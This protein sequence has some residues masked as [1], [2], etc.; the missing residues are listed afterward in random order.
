MTCAIGEE[1]GSSVRGP[2]EANNVVDLSPTQELVSRHGM[3]GMGINTRV[4]PICRNIEDTARILDAIAGY[5]PKDPLTVFSIGRSPKSHYRTFA[6][7]RDL[8]GLRIGVVRE[9]ST[10]T[11]FRSTPPANLP[12]T[13]SRNWSSW[14]RTRRCFRMTS[15]YVR[16]D[17]LRPMA[18]FA[19]SWNDTC[20]TG[21]MRISGAIPTS[22]TRQTGTTT[23]A[24]P[25]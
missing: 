18:R 12:P 17:N 10:R 2:A 23:R 15:I 3:M 16:S 8:V 19:T 14:K 5:D 21:E 20:A 22:S 7:A 6:H 24:S 25:P 4:G 11:C 13:T 1:T 9:Y